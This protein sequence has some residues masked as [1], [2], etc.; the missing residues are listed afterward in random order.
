MNK[1]YLFSDGDLWHTLEAQRLAALSSVQSIPRD[2]FLATSVET[3]VEHIME[4][5]SFRPLVLRED[6][7]RMDRREVQVN[8]R[9]R[10]EYDLDRGGGDVLVPG[11]ELSFFLPFSGDSGF[12]RLAPNMRFSVMPTGLVDGQGSVLKMTYSNTVDTE[13]TWFK[14]QLDNDLKAIRELVKAQ[15]GMVDQYHAALPAQIRAEVERRKSELE[16]LQG[17]VSSFDIPLIA[18]AG[19][20]EFKPIEITRKIPHPLPRPPV[21]GYSPEPAISNET[22]DYILRVIRHAG[23]SF[24]GVPQTYLGMGEE[25]LRD[26][27]LSHLN[28]VFEGKATGET[29]R[30]YGKTDIR[31]EE[32]SR[33]AFVGECK[34]WSGEKHL[35]AALD[36][37]LSYLTWRDC[38]AA[39]IVFNKDVAAFSEIQATISPSLKNH[40][41]FL[42]AYETGHA[43]EWRFV[44]KSVEDAGR[45][46]TVHV[47]AFN[48]YVTPM[49]AAKRH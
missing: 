33:S 4:E 43:G 25:A 28:V 36:Q 17:L 26:N 10:F 47:F 46:I 12:F 38:K 20:P 14:Q 21:A 29:F 40:P 24:E 19:M 2:Q 44:F 18:K 39:L 23:A 16:K 34:L 31:I 3:I 6:Q 9:G 27:I 30:K 42:R 45:E 37:L 13:Q 5:S 15:H 1:F 32:Q 8:V 41:L 11:H 35:H 22:Y 48:L 49:R 7:M